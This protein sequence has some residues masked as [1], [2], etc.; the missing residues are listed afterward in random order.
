MRAFLNQTLK[1]TTLYILG[2]LGPNN[3]IISYSAYF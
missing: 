2:A 3:K 1:S